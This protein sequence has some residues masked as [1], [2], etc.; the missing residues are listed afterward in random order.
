MDGFDYVA[1]MQV[2]MR[3]LDTMNHVNNAVYATY[4]EQARVDYFADVIGEPLPELD[5]VIANIDVQFERPITS[6]ADVA[7]VGVRVPELGASSFPIQYEVRANRERKATGETTLVAFDPETE[8]AR[9]LP[10]DWRE[11]IA[12]FGGIG[13]T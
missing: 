10:E 1:E 9:E 5:A 4:L 13:G 12:A 3:D 8:S 11:S 6:D 2:R 7:R